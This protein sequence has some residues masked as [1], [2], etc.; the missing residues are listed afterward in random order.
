MSRLIAPPS[1]MRQEMNMCK[2]TPG[3]PG[4]GSQLN[5]H[6][7]TW[8]RLRR[9]ELRAR[10]SAHDPRRA[11]DAAD[12]PRRLPW[13]D[14]LRRVPAQSR[15]GDERIERSAAEVGGARR[16]GADGVARFVPSDPEGPRLVPG[17]VDADGLGRPLR[18]WPRGPRG[19]DPAHRLRTRGRGRA[20]MRTL[21][22]PHHAARPARGAGV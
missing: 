4:P 15:T 21:R 5:L 7:A 19:V 17:G 16:A 3:R 6:H 12:R 18:T 1:Q 11:L 10:P 20:A 13:I 14:P 9:P 22:R 8:E 2:V